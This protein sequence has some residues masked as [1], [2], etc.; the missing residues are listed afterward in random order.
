VG[1]PAEAN[2][3][4]RIALGL[5]GAGLH[6]EASVRIAARPLF[7]FDYSVAWSSKRTDPSL[8]KTSSQVASSGIVGV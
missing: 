6:D 7:G 4:L 3:V 1:C 2:D 5:A 8:T